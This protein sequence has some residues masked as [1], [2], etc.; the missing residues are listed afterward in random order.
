VEGEVAGW[1]VPDL[2]VGN[3][4]EVLVD[5]PGRVGVL[6]RELCG[7]SILV[8]QRNDREIVLGIG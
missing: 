3:R 8:C 7:T 2:I 1:A 5:Q 6:I 4:V